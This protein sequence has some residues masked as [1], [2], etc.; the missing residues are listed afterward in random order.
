M[1]VVG[2]EQYGLFVKKS[3]GNRVQDGIGFSGSRR[4]LDIGQGV[5][6]PMVDCQELIQIDSPVQQRQRVPALSGQAV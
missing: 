4:S 6:K 5:F 1:I 2:R 3:S